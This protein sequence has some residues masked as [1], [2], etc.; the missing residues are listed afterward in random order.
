MQPGSLTKYSIR[1]HLHLFF[2][3]VNNYTNFCVRVYAFNSKVQD[4]QINHSQTEKNGELIGCEWKIRE[5]RMSLN[6]KC[7]IVLHRKE[8]KHKPKFRIEKV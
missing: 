6:T 2:F 7:F 3:T 4:G 8:K 1:L 5:N